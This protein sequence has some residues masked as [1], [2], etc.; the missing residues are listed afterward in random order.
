MNFCAARPQIVKVSRY[1]LIV[2]D[3][4]RY[5]VPVNF[6]GQNLWVKAYVD[7]VEILNLN[8]VIA[9]HIRYYVRGHTELRLEHYLPALERKP[10]AVTHATVVRQLPSAFQQVRERMEQAHSTGYKDFL[11]VLLLMREYTIEEVN[12]AIIAI[13]PPL[14]NVVSLRQH[15]IYE[16]SQPSTSVEWFN[17]PTERLI[18][19]ADTHQYDQ[20]LRGVG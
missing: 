14:A 8:R 16:R 18:K 10:H 4:N 2:I 1:S 5:S 12:Q 17:G 19:E 6:V 9:T 3:R 15:L 13:G 20:L 11:E 7:R